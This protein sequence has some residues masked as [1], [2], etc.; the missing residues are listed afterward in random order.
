MFDTEEF[1]IAVFC[2]VDDGLKELT[3]A[4]PIRSRGFSPALS[5]AEVMTMEIV[6]EDPG[7][8]ADKAL[9]QYFRDHW[10]SLF[11]QL[12]SRS[13]FVR[14][15]SNLWQYKQ[16]L[17]QLLAHRLGAFDDPVHLVDGFPVSLCCLTYARRCCSFKGEASY[18]YCA[19]K[20]EKFLGFRGHLLGSVVTRF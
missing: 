18:G 12:P 10:L 6:G 2:C 20:D 17:E 3:Q 5:D 8:D 16:W 13:T 11:P 19:A 7:F 15:G 1:I 9:W 14:Q 4:Q